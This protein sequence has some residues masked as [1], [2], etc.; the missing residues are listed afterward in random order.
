MRAPLILGTVLTASVIGGLAAPG[1]GA[2][3][4]APRRPPAEASPPTYDVSMQ[5]AWIPMRDGVRL[6]ADL[7]VPKGGKGKERF[8][9]LLE[10]LPYRKTEERG[11]RY[12][13]YAYF[14]RRGYI[15]ARVDIRGTG[16]SEGRLIE[17]E[18]SEQEQ[19]DGE[20]VIAWLARQPF[21]SGQVGMF[22]ISWGGFNSL[23]MAMRNP[24]A[25]KAIIAIDATDDLYEDDVHFMDGGMHV[26]SWE[27]SMDLANA[28]P[29][30]PGYVVDEAFFRDRFDTPPWMLTYKRQQRDGP[31][32]D[33]TALKTRYDSIR[34]PTFMIGGWYDG[35]RDSVPRVLEHLKAPV[36][37]I[38]G[39]WSHFFP[40]DAQPQPR[41]EWR[42]EAVRWFDQ[43]LKGRDTGI[44]AEPRFAVFVRRWHPPGSDLDVI[45]G[46]WRWEEGWPIARIQPRPFY[47][48]PNHTL[49]AA[50]PGS[51]TTAGGASPAAAGPAGAAHQLRYVPT[52]GIEAGGPVMW[53]GD[54]A[55]DQRP[56]DAL[57]LV[58]DSDPLEE[59]VE[60]L[61]LP[62]AVLNASADAP[63]ARWFARLSDVAPDGTV[64][65]I[66]GAGF[67][68][69]HRESARNPKPL[70]PG[71]PVTLDIEMH[72]TSWVFPKAHRIRL[73][74]G[75]SQWPMI[76]P[77]PYPMTTTLHL[78][79]PDPTRLLLPVVP[80]ADRPA[81][82]FLPPE[83]DP[84]LPGFEVL[85]EGTTSGYGEITSIERSPQRHATKIVATNGGGMKFP[86]GTERYTE[87]IVHEAQDDH[88]EATSVQGE[89]S[90]TV[91]LPD[92][93][94]RWEA[95]LTFRSDRDNFYYT[96]FRRL[97]KDGTIVREKTWEDTIPRDYQ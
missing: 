47:P 29:G 81:P 43:H 38:V 14:V 27:M 19:K 2:A 75:N 17:Y 55:P 66:T 64:T 41:I 30:A 63:L 71:R 79:G 8:P 50:S 49:G 61:G 97:L 58:Y 46:E 91:Q 90:T 65:L 37:A 87:S 34:I 16:N 96:Y 20:D 93:T 48:Q 10:Y 80:R 40:H 3:G 25:L 74:V 11:D 51:A 4:A 83:A 77:T 53:W 15:V 6:A 36:K 18:Y 33:R 5:E 35:Y 23:H 39:P 85:D 12:G 70:E 59:E 94:L 86:W 67:N 76:W 82:K 89:Y 24:P 69:A 32:W 84:K 62:R 9:V 68:G 45:P 52:S 73:A 95:R 54:M 26:D 13:L 72:F 21:S 28:M 88:P 60:I 44:M 31:F 22:G 56:T 42:H 92:R 1:A 7:H 78:G 57:A